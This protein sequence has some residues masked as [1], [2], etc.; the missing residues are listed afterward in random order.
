VLRGIQVSASLDKDS[1]IT[2]M[3]AS[4]GERTKRAG[5]KFRGVPRV[6]CTKEQPAIAE[7]PTSPIL[8]SVG[9]HRGVLKTSYLKIF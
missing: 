3:N 2:L 4:N 6:F 8:P 9:V 1:A 7:L 5:D